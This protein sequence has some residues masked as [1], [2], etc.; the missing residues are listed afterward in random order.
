MYQYR[1]L[2]QFATVD[3]PDFEEV[4]T[5]VEKAVENYNQK[6]L[7]AKN[8]KQIV[9]KQILNPRTLE[10]VLESRAEL[11]YPSKALR[12]FSAYMVDPHIDGNLTR[13]I[14]GKQLFKMVAEKM[15][16]QHSEEIDPADL[17]KKLVQL[18]YNKHTDTDITMLQK[19]EKTLQEW[20]EQA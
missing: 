6:S 8:P 5:V 11:P 14:S 10:I 15:P 1:I 4:E 12:L 16:V 3:A 20:E 18:L 9:G 7:I 19:I 17:I 13:Y 2:V